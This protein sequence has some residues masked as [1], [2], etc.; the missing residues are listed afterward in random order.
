MRTLVI[1]G[2]MGLATTAFAEPASDD[3]QPAGTQYEIGVRAAIM[4]AS[5]IGGSFAGGKPGGENAGVG[6]SVK[7][8]GDIRV[9]NHVHVGAAIPVMIEGV[10][11]TSTESDVGL[12][13][14]VVFDAELTSVT[15]GYVAFEPAVIVARLPGGEWWTGYQVSLA[16]GVRVALSRSVNLVG[17]VTAQPTTISGTVNFPTQM[18]ALVHGAVKTFYFGGGAGLETHF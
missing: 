13:P 10:G 16:A 2:W 18:D 17:E 1:V 4:P 12:G 9:A 15:A 8:Y 5:W 7:I 3:D 11:P 6:T 14:R